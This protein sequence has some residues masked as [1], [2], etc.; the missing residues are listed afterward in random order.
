MFPREWL[1]KVETAIDCAAAWG[2]VAFARRRRRSRMNFLGTKHQV[3]PHRS[4]LA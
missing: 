3:G 1:L 4:N 2:T